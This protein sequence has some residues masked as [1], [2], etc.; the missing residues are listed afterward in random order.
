VFGVFLYSNYKKDDEES[1]E[2][3]YAAVVSASSIEMYQE[4][5][6]EGG[7]R[8]IQVAVRKVNQ[9]QVSTSYYQKEAK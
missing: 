5:T 3:R 6:I 4:G 8:D 9:N 1:K 7:G 2:Q